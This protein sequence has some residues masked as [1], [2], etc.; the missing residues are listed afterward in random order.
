MIQ[1]LLTLLGGLNENFE[2]TPQGFLPDKIVKRLWTKGDIG[3]VL[4]IGCAFNET[5]GSNSK[6]H[7]VP[8][9]T[10]L[11]NFI[12]M[13]VAVIP[14][15]FLFSRAAGERKFIRNPVGLT[16]N[17][18]RMDMKT[19]FRINFRSRLKRREA[20]IVRNDGACNVTLRSPDG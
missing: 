14:E 4:R 11:P 8:H 19:G 18:A 10:E 13:T 9:S 6:S 3:R 2:I 7:A 15:N 12:G 1:G 5:V 16:A 20:K 17:K